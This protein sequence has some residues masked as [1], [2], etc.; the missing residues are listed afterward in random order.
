MSRKLERTTNVTGYS[1][2][3]VKIQS[4]LPQMFHPN[5]STEH[6]LAQQSKLIQKH[7]EATVKKHESK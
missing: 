1:P 4:P 2:S 5:E 6:L 3:N 7:N